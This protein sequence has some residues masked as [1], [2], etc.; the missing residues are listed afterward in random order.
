[1]DSAYTRRD[2][3]HG[4]WPSD[5]EQLQ[6][7]YVSDWEIYR[8]RLPGGAHGDWIAKRLRPKDGSATELRGS[9]SDHLAEQLRGEAGGTPS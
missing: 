7:L 4:P 8:E 2:S 9:T 1:M 5:I 3:L 6:A